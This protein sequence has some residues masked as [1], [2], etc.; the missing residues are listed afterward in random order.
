ME[1]TSLIDPAVVS[2]D[3][4]ELYI[5]EQ[6]YKWLNVD[7]IWETLECYL[8]FTEIPHSDCNPLN[9]THICEQQQQDEKLLAL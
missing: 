6:E 3:E 2:N 1:G 4:E 9:H 7:K 5:L 8:N